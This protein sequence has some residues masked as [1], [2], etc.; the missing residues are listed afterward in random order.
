MSESENDAPQP[1]KRE[2]SPEMR[3]GV[4]RRALITDE[5]RTGAMDAVKKLPSFGGFLGMALKET[6]GQRDERML[7]NLWQL[8]MNRKP[9]PDELSEAKKLMREA[10]T[11]DDKADALV[12]VAWALTQTQEFEDLK[13]P[14]G[15]LIRGFY[16]LALDRLPTDQE[17]DTA[18]DI[19][20]EAED[21]G[22]RTAALEG[23]LTALLR[24]WEC[25]LR[26]TPGR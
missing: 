9:R 22:S 21:P 10:D 12:D 6:P 16:K 15:L 24:S 23:L 17:L 4:S 20:R 2:I 26:K 19:M 13:R 18:L 14:N 11:S 7:E 5:L 3:R 25:V 1:P 8:L